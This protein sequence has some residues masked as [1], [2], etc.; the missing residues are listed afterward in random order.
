MDEKT[1]IFMATADPEIIPAFYEKTK[2][3][4]NIMI[5]Y[6]YLRGAAYKVAEKYRDMIHLLYLDSGAYS[7]AQGKSSI[8]LP[9][10]L[11]YLKMYGH[12]FDVVFNFDDKFGDPDHNWRNQVYLEQGLAG[13]GIKPV[14]VVHDVNDPFAEFEMYA[15][16][17]HQ[18]VGIGSTTKL[19][20]NVFEKMK[21]EFPNVKV[22]MF[23][24]LERGMLFKHKPYSADASTFTQ[25]AAD[26]NILYWDPI[27][28]KEYKIDVG[29]REKKGSNFIHFKMFSHKANLEKFLET[30]FNYGY[31]DLLTSHEAKSIVNI[32]F[33]TQLQDRVNQS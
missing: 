6:Q 20:D 3:Q 27:D 31:Q 24:T 16:G 19:E 4:L 9:E 29:E 2:I 14:P 17:G 32:Y 28:K 10:Y 22:H 18:Y 25:E 30:T 5:S 13:T 1:E 15:E 33:F 23:G 26:G 11:G 7:A 21:K 8:T 12:L